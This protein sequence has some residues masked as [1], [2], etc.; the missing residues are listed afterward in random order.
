MAVV[1]QNKEMASAS[2]KM[3]K[4]EEDYWIKMEEK[5]KKRTTISVRAGVLGDKEASEKIHQE[6]DELI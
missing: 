6:I 3:K 1:E 5:A 4:G 2:I